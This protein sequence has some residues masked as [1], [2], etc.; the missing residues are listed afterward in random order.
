MLEIARF[1]AL[2]F[3]PW[4]PLDSRIVASYLAEQAARPVLRVRIMQEL[5][6]LTS[7]ASKERKDE[8]AAV[9][10]AE[11]V[12]PDDVI[13]QGGALAPKRALEIAEA[14]CDGLAH[15][16]RQHVVHRDIKAENIFLRHDGKVKIGDLRRRPRRH[17]LR[18]RPPPR[19]A[20]R[21]PDLFSPTGG[22][23]EVARHE[24]VQLV[25]ELGDVPPPAVR[26]A[27]FPVAAGFPTLDRTDAPFVF[28]D[29]GHLLVA[30]TDVR[31][32]LAGLELNARIRGAAGVFGLAGFVGALR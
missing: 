17:L 6:R 19:N 26:Q 12:T 24:V 23:T 25:R 1:V 9:E 10:Y 8:A 16:H 29:A 3:R 32:V 4:L 18:R 5:E 13:S 7:V 20:H 11:G 15:A 27:L 14:I 21:P 22:T 2:P 31:A 30:A 28:S